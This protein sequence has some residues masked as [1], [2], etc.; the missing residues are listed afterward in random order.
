MQSTVGY[1][2]VSGVLGL[3]GK[4]SGILWARWCHAGSLVSVMVGVLISQKSA[5]VTDQA[6]AFSRELFVKLHDL[7]LG[8]VLNHKEQVDSRGTVFSFL[9]SCVGAGRWALL[10]SVAFQLYLLLEGK[11]STGFSPWARAGPSSPGQALQFL[12]HHHRGACFS[13]VYSLALNIKQG[14]PD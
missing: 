14:V 2:Q 4:F 5:D 12:L 9:L 8:F 3:M 6:A 10:I 11:P 7:P 1:D 13:S